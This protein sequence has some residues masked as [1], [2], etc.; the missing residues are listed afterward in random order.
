MGRK[1]NLNSVEITCSVSACEQEEPSLQKHH[2]TSK[3]EAMPLSL[4]IP[5]DSALT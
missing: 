1:T 3:A 2:C 4:S 5:R